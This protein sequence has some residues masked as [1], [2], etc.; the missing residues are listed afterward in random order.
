MPHVTIFVTSVHERSFLFPILL[1]FNVFF[2]PNLGRK[3][4]SFA[5]PILKICFQVLIIFKKIVP[6]ISFRGE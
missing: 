4:K 5:P 2:V 3:K 1:G 6:S